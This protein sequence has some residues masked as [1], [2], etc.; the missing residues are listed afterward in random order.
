MADSYEN[1]EILQD[2]GNK[3]KDEYS[4]FT[5]LNIVIIGKTGVGK[6][7]LINTIFGQKLAET[8]IGKPVTQAIRKIEKKDIPLVLYDTPGMELKGDNT[9]QNLLDDVVDLINNG[10][11]TGDV[12]QAIHCVWYCINASS[13]RIEPTEIQFLRDLAIKTKYC[14]VPL[15]VILT[16][17]ILKENVKQIKEE[18]EK[19]NLPTDGGMEIK[20][21]GIEQLAW[22][23]N[24]ILP[25]YVKA[26]FISIQDASIALKQ[27]KARI[28]IKSTVITVMAI[29]GLPIPTSDAPLIMTAQMDMIA[30]ITAAFGLRIEKE[31]YM[32]IIYAILGTTGATS[33]GKKIVSNIFKMIPGV[34]TIAGGAISAATAATLTTALGETYIVILGQIAKG[35]ISLADLSTKK[36]Q[37]EMQHEFK[38]QMKKASK[39]AI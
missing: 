24:D 1:L 10:T 26:T 18:I 33:A 28:V 20:A 19:E 12:N 5:T 27:E 39:L 38:A 6:S 2:I 36:V 13:G 15:V 34:G 9:A 30:K 25:D 21:H 7:T 3:I 31:K 17:S 37:R 23:M 11:E 16:K 4:N 35:K 8:G 29:G 32:T 22:E 14:N